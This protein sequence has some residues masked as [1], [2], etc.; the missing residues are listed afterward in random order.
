[1]KGYFDY[2]RVAFLPFVLNSSMSLAESWAQNPYPAPEDKD[3]QPEVTPVP[4]PYPAP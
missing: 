3:K 4:N 2:Q 1:M